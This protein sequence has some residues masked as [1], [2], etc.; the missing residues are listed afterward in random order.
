[1][2]RL[3][4]VLV[5]LVLSVSAWAQE[6]PIRPLDVP[7]SFAGT[8]GEL[9]HDHFH[10]GLDWRVGGQ[11][12]DPIHAVKS[13]WVSRVSVSVWGYGN[14]LY[15]THPDGTTSV[16]GHML[17]FR[18][19]IAA[20]VEEAQY[21]QESFNV[22][23]TFE[24]GEIPVQQGDIIGQVG[25]TGS[26]AGP[27][28]H[29]EIRDTERDVPMNPISCG[30]YQPVDKTAP[31]FHRVCFYGLDDSPVPEPWRVHNLSKPTAVRDTL[32]LPARSYVAFDVTDA[33]EGTGAKLAVE[34]YRV[35]YDDSLAFAFKLGEIPFD[36]GRYIKSLIQYGESRRG[37]RDLV[38]SLVDPNNLLSDHITSRNDGILELTDDEIHRVR[39]EAVDEHGN[40]ATVRFRV[41]RDT[42]LNAPVPKDDAANR[43]AWCWYTQNL[44][45]DSSMTFI[46][47]AGALYN[48]INFTYRCIGGPDPSRG[49][50][51]DI[52]QIG[53]PDIPLQLPGEL[54]IAADIP[55]ELEGKAYMANYGKTLTNSSVRVRFG[56]YCVAVDTTAPSIRFFENKN[57][58]VNG[59]TIRIRVSDNASGIESTR[60]EIDGQWYLSMLKRDV[61]SLVL[62][63][64]RVSR[65]KHEIKIIV[66]DICGNQAY[67]TRTFTY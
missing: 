4:G 39:L 12:G 28:L 27:H 44:V 62:D 5:T 29:L 40:R 35:F 25:S 22:N 36:K 3:A 56:T 53:D 64:K 45:S 58:I 13:G 66:T 11:V 52:W 60:V 38:K 31:Q 51:S 43:L 15:I 16:Y 30:Y 59:E 65:G 47:P 2:K 18:D 14:G 24:P 41:R 9:R 26:S 49:I 63:E 23:L 48:N 32:R 37:G 6:R 17:G 33:Q 20:R 50:W 42:T 7:M 55:E 10:G 54:E 61:V 67:E 1:M 19:D 46:L 34:E 21:A 8:Y 57:G